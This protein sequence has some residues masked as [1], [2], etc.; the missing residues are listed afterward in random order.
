MRD[1]FDAVHP[2]HPVIRDHHVEVGRPEEL[3]TL[4]TVAGQLYG[5]AK[6]FQQ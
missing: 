3:Q 4:L 6:F 2:R 1:H 5:A